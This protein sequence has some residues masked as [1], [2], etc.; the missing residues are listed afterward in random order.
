M[1][2]SHRQLIAAA[3]C[4]ERGGSGLTK[5]MSFVDSGSS[6]RRVLTVRQLKNQQCRINQTEYHTP[7]LPFIFLMAYMGR[8]TSNCAAGH[9]LASTEV[10]FSKIHLRKKSGVSENFQWWKR[11]NHLKGGV[12]IKLHR[13]KPNVK[14]SKSDVVKTILY[15]D[16][17]R[18]D[19]PEK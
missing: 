18:A 14:G 12:G 9:L 15:R 11:S 13:R 4:D 8:C 7:Y 17:Q 1:C 10:F 16:L 2:K 5:N 3:Q 6:G 19:P